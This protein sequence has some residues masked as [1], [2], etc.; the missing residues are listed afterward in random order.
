MRGIFS[1]GH[2]SAHNAVE[3]SNGKFWQRTFC[4]HGVLASRW[5][6][7][8]AFPLW[9]WLICIKHALFSFF[10]LHLEDDVGARIWVLKREWV[11]LIL[12]YLCCR[13]GRC[14]TATVSALIVCV[15]DP[16]RHWALL[17]F[18]T[19]LASFL[20]EW[21]H[22][23]RNPRKKKTKNK[24]KC[25]STLS[26]RNLWISTGLQRLCI[27]RATLRFVPAKSWD[28]PAFLAGNVPEVFGLLMQ[29]CK[30]LSTWL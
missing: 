13:S 16:S 6:L 11:P 26:H 20:D 30:K 27:T 24:I 1:K 22:A 7:K 15:S 9:E 21:Q 14:Y 23:A 8:W 2:L 5:L 4:W 18:V 19:A 12:I 17:L 10:F 28:I 29:L 3:N 25:M